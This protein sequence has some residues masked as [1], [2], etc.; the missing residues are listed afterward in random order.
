ME[1][2][3]YLPILLAAV[4]V[5]VVINTFLKRF[6]IPTV[7]G[8]IATGISVSFLFGLHDAFASLSHLA[9]FGIVFL[10]FTIGLEFSFKDLVAMRR[11]VLLYG[12]LQLLI[13]AGLLGAVALGAGTDAKSAMIIGLALAL[14][15][16]AIVLKSLQEKGHTHTPYGKQSVG[17]L[18]FQDLAVIPILLMLSIFASAGGTVGEMLKVIAFDAVAVI[19]ILFIIGKFLLD[20]LLDLVTRTD[21]SE[22]FLATVL[23]LAVGA[24]ELAHRF[25]FTYSLGAFLAGMMLSETTYKYQ[26]EA[27]LIPFRDL[28]M[29]LFFVTVGMQIDPVSILEHLGRV[30]LIAAGIMALKFSVILFFLRYFTRLRSALKTSLALAQVGE[31]A[32]AVFTLASAAHLLEPETVQILLAASVLSMVASVFILANLGAI[33]DRFYPEPEPV[34]IDVDPGL[35]N[36]IVVCGY[37]P[38]GRNVVAMLQ[39]MQMRY[40]ILEHDITAVRLGESRGEPIYFANAANMDILRS[41]NI[42]KAASVIVAVGNARHLRL[43]CEAL[44]RVGEEINIVIKAANRT[45]ERMLADLNIGHIILQSEEMAAMLVHEAVRCELYNTAKE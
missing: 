13:T 27:A 34:T 35:S 8:Y 18:L 29:G 19:A 10:M 37:G 39:R 14:S 33:T 12:S 30:V 2:M 44:N 4:F 3:N 42:E 1:S 15:S 5:S 28:L 22:I 6:G 43:I 11:E 32:L 23:F 16:T 21:T 45:E 25:G 31:F 9:E 26:V 24:A 20:R 38:M 36:H 7:I 41:F 40:V 17:I